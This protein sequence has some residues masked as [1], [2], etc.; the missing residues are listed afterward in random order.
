MSTIK[1]GEGHYTVAYQKAN[2]SETQGYGSISLVNTR[3]IEEDGGRRGLANP[4]TGQV[5]DLSR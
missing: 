2:K 4:P 3:L 5:W 1:S